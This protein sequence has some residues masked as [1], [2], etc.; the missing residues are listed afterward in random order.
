M[1][2]LHTGVMTGRGGGPRKSALHPNSFNLHEPPLT[3]CAS[4]GCESSFYR[5]FG[6]SSDTS[7]PAAVFTDW[8]GEVRAVLIQGSCA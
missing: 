1:G 8:L 2:F 7:F 5:S 6:T 3:E 4:R